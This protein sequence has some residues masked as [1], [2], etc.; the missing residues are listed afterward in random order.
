[1]KTKKKKIEKKLEFI[2]NT[3]NYIYAS[4]LSLCVF[5]M[6]FSVD[7]V[8]HSRIGMHFKKGNIF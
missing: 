8:V 2:Y 1:M 5:R 3:L 4:L 6:T 7:S